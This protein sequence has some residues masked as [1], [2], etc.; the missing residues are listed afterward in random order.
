MADYSNNEAAGRNMCIDA[1]VSKPSWEAAMINRG[2]VFEETIAKTKAKATENV[3]KK[4]EYELYLRSLHK[5]EEAF[6]TFKHNIIQANDHRFRKGGLWMTWDR[7]MTNLSK[8]LL[9]LF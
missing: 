6:V 1:F 2:R 9:T 8:R 3:A 7:G 4:T 5:Q